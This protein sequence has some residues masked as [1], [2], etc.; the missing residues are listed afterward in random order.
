[1]AQITF[2]ALASDDIDG[3]LLDLAA[4]AGHQVARRYDGLFERLYARLA[5]HPH[6]GSPRP[7]LGEIFASGS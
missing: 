1:M 3:L 6:G 7:A 4:K 2:A 5:E